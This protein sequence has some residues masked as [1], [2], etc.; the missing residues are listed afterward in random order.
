VVKTDLLYIALGTYSELRR[1]E[2]KYVDAIE[3]AKEAYDC[4]AVTYNPVHPKV[5]GAACT[6]I[7]SL[8]LNGEFYDGERYAQATLDS[9]KDPMNK[10]DQQS[11][12]VARGYHNLANI[13]YLQNKDFKKA[14]ILARESLRIRTLL[15]DDSHEN[16][17]HSSDL[18]ACILQAQ[19][20]LSSETKKLIE[21]SLA[22]DIR[23][24]GPD[25]VNTAVGYARLGQ[26]Y[27]LL[28]EVR[29]TVEK[30][31]EYLRLSHSKFKE[32]LRINSKTLGPNNEKTLK[33]S[34]D[35]LFISNKLSKA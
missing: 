33:F 30:R 19:G 20:N 6:L 23:T 8:I 29:Q 14:E 7:E 21:H 34:S 25:G 17:G 32:A 1:T 18:L 35:L 10:L 28:A 2:G 26:Y 5:Q 24:Y 27:H 11:N 12:D 16:S 31:V 15:Y 4:V 13:I 3:L 9:L 22:V